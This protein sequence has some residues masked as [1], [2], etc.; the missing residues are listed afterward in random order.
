MAFL[1]EHLKKFLSLPNVKEVVKRV[2]MMQ[3]RPFLHNSM[4]LFPKWTV[5]N[6][7]LYRTARQA[8]G[9]S[10]MVGLFATGQFAHVE[11]CL[12]VRCL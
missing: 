11:F 8:C 10:D 6:Y 9:G 3:L 5:E 7:S 12:K 1:I 2:A 4:F